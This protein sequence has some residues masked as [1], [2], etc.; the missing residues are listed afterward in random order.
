MD[1]AYLPLSKQISSAAAAVLY[2]LKLHWTKLCNCQTATTF[3][4][5]CV[6]LLQQSITTICLDTELDWN[7]HK[8]MLCLVYAYSGTASVCTSRSDTLNDNTV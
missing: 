1:P 5:C 2:V 4:L 6:P 8:Q 7:V 3:G